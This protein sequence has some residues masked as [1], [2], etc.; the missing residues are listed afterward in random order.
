MLILLTVSFGAIKLDI[1]LLRRYTVYQ[2]TFKYRIVAS[3]TNNYNS[4]V[5]GSIQNAV[6]AT[7]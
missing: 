6:Q 4:H 3:D 1:S 5:T 2:C 7:I